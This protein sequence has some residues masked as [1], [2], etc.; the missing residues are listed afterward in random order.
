MND[1]PAVYGDEE[2]I[3]QILTSLLSNAVKFT[4]KGGITITASVSDMGINPGEAPL[5]LEIC[6]ADTGIGIKSEDLG[7]IFDKFVQVD[8]TLVR[9]YE[10]TGLGTQHCQRAGE[11][12]TRVQYG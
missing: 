6:I 11:T 1:L 10:G 7:K 8:F 9:R 4:H 2:K 12:C 5:F 3:K